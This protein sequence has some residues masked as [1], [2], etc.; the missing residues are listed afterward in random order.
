MQDNNNKN[1]NLLNKVDIKNY[2]FEGAGEPKSIP[3][4][5]IY[6]KF[7]LKN[8]EYIAFSESKDEDEE[9]DMMF[10]RIE[11]NNGKRIAKWIDNSV[12][13]EEVLNEFNKK[14]ANIDNKEN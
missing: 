9:I 14:L 10:A 6:M 4:D 2:K 5:K 8:N 12:E 3:N 7:Y 13:F 11:H 1:V